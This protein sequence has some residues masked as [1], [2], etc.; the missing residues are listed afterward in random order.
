MFYFVKQPF[1]VRIFFN[2][3]VFGRRECVQ[4]IIKI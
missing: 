1:F 2:Y 3:L 4:Q